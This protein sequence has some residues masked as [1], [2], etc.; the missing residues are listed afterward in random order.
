MLDAELMTELITPPR[1]ENCASGI[2]RI[3]DDDMSGKK[4][5]PTPFTDD[6]SRFNLPNNGTGTLTVNIVVERVTTSGAQRMLKMTLCVIHRLDRWLEDWGGCIACLSYNIVC[7]TFISPATLQ[8][9]LG[10]P[11]QPID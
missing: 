9:H 5:F 6:Q 3:L 10:G 7:S 11:E 2:C 1:V 4:R 8:N